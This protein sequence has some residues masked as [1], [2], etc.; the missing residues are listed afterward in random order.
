MKYDFVEIA[1]I[2][3]AAKGGFYEEAKTLY[4]KFLK[5]DPFLFK[6]DCQDMAVILRVIGLPDEAKRYDELARVTIDTEVFME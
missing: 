3:K 1:H 6:Q 2:F 5:Q 4:Y